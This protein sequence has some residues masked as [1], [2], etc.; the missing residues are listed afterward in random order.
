MP[1]S[2]HAWQPYRRLR[3][4]LLWTIL[5]SLA[6]LGL[7][8]RL[9]GKLHSGKPAF[10]GLVLGLAASGWAAAGLA[11]FPCPRCGKRFC[12]TETFGD[13]FTRVCLHCGLPKWSDPAGPPLG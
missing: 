7:G 1:R 11:G 6:V 2:S 5:A 9:A 10:A 13:G 8:L 4:R 12:H 3:W